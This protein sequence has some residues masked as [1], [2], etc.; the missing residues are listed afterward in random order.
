M[1]KLE[2][3]LIF[4]ISFLFT[5]AFSTNVTFPGVAQLETVSNTT[6]KTSE[7]SEEPFQTVKPF[8]FL[9]NTELPAF[10]VRVST[11]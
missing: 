4:F 1:R 8:F 10:N 11:R 2:N 5:I 6:D 7:Q 9:F 3:N